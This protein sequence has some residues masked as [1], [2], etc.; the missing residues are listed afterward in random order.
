MTLALV[1]LSAGE[2]ASA[3]PRLLRHMVAA[4]YGTTV[5]AVREWPI[6]DYLDACRF[7]GVTGGR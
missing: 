2:Q 5:D 3:P 7:L 6:D 1:K 4:R